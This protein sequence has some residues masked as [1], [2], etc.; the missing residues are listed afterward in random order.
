MNIRA[1]ANTAGMSQSG[2]RS[3]DVVKPD[4]ENGGGKEGI[5]IVDTLLVMK[6]V[7]LDFYF[8]SQPV[9]F[10]GYVWR[11]CDASFRETLVWQ[12]RE[13]RQRQY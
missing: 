8:C 9:S 6:H 11:V 1:G 12:M 10:A 2:Q 4:L 3:G 7:R 5:C 13:R